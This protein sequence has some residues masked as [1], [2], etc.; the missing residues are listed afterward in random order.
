MKRKITHVIRIVLLITVIT[1]TSTPLI[2]QTLENTGDM[3]DAQL[4]QKGLTP[5]DIE[6]LKAARA[7]KQ[8]SSAPVTPADTGQPRQQNAQ[9]QDQV[10]ETPEQI[11]ERQSMQ[12]IFGSSLFA[13][14]NLTFEPNLRIATP[15]NYVIGPE[16]QIGINLNGDNEASYSLTVSPEGS[17]RVE[18]AGVISVNG[19]TVEQA[20]AKIKA[21]LTPTYPALRSGKTTL[22]VDIGNIR[23]IKVTVLG[24]VIKPGSYTL[25]SLAT[26]FNA[27]YA[28]GGPN[29]NGSFREIE[30]IRNNKI[31]TTLD[32]Y[33]FLL[34]GY[35]VNNLRLQDQDVIHIPVYKTHA[36]L[37]GYI[38]HPAIFEVMPNE[39]LADVIKFAGS[40]ADAAYTAKIKV[41]QNT[42]KERRVSD[43]SSAEFASFHPKNGDVFVVD[44]ILDRVEN[45]VVI[46][47]AVYR[48]GS[49]ELKPGLTLLGL[50]KEADGIKGD[51]FLTRGQL[52]RVQQ[53]ST[54][55]LVPFNLGEII[56]GKSPDIVL[57]REDK[58]TISSVLNLKDRYGVTI[59][60]EVR[61]AGVFNY[62]QNMTL[63]DLIFLAGG[64]KDGATSKQIEIARR[65]LDTGTNVFS[66]KS[67]QIF[68]VDVDRSLNFSGE[69][70]IL[71]PSDI[72]TVR[73][74]TGYNEQKRVK[75]EGEVLHPGYYVIANKNE[76]ISDLVVRAGG[77]TPLA[78]KRGAVLKRPDTQN[79]S[80]VNKVDE[81]E[82]EKFKQENLIRLQSGDSSKVAVAPQMPDN[83][84]VGIDLTDILKN[85]GS[86]KDLILKEEDVLK[87]PQQLQTVKITGEVLYPVTA[88]YKNA[89]NF[90]YYISQAGGFT[91]EALRRHA[92]VVYANGSVDNT[93]HFLFFTDHPKVT[94]G[95][96][97]FIPRRAP[98]LRR[99][100]PIELISVS[101]ALASLGAIILGIIKL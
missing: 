86:D 73:N 41:F 69:K 36:E 76:R 79:G 52:F 40:F 27:L 53:D 34:K 84:T 58:V 71:E 45:R 43:I 51:A 35:Q 1:I 100:S 95:A 94:P 24:E 70:F 88:V 39:T 11:A 62:A 47:G 16:D 14:S 46:N 25:P 57:Q 65:V 77:L 96:E 66:I 85:P 2:A 67:A 12:K 101:T 64:F 37:Q 92:Y 38:K 18:F 17:I 4:A 98:D 75:V 78:Y 5:Q 50:I 20:T 87:I 28:S 26:V 91:P 21:R 89:S 99:F 61:Q 97:I 81:S 13:N 44:P 59:N 74:N 23:S 56:N 29:K 72:V 68:H 8:G 9:P 83:N 15:K 55:Q 93:K 32:M 48:P 42:D 60:G 80:G 30:L 82:I 49:F 33:N 6:K 22:T 54:A 10:I 3:T 19:L 90:N 31:I 63:Q 7:S